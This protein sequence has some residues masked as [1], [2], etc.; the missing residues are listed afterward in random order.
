MQA[1]HHSYHDHENCPFCVIYLPDLGHLL[2]LG[3]AIEMSNC[4][5]EIPYMLLPAL[6]NLKLSINA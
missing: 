1:Q 2:V 6:F 3:I 4:I 5:R